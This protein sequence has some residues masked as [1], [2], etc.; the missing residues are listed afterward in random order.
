MF[1]LTNLQLGG[2]Y[3][4]FILDAALYFHIL[5]IFISLSVV[6][7]DKLTRLEKWPV[8]RRK[9]RVGD[10]SRPPRIYTIATAWKLLLLLL[11]LFVLMYVNI[12]V[13][14]R[15]ISCQWLFSLD[16]LMNEESQLF[17]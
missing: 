15:G 2:L 10:S 11:L 1:N 7:L 6:V 14:V 13:R 9:S 17:K 16:I 3:V 12:V 4:P 8:N 5:I